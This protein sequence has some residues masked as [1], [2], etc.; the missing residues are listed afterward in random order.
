MSRQVSCPTCGAPL[1]IENAFTKFIVCQYCGQSLAVLDTGVD[2]TGKVAKLAEYPSRLSVGAHG[3]LKGQG[4]R[5]LGR[6]RYSSVDG[7]WDDWY[8]QMDDGKMGWITEDEGDLTF[9]SKTTLTVPVPPFDQVRVGGFLSFGSDRLF[10]SEKGQSRVL[11]S[12]G[13]LPYAA[14][15]DRPVAYIN[16]NAGGKAIQLMLDGDAI[17][18][19]TGVPLE[20][21]DVTVS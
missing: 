21:R 18:L 16:G 6:V 10:V 9:V 19:N 11:G 8:I 12:E 15:P 7:F 3:S 5:V 4:F 13:Q 20:F 2:P 1:T 14:A 17:R